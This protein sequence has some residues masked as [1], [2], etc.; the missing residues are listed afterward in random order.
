MLADLNAALHR[1]SGTMVREA[2]GLLS[3]VAMLV[4]GLNLA[5]PV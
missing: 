2:V 3:L 4:M 5:V 1:S